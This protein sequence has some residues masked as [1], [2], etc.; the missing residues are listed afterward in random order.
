[1]RW[2]VPPATEILQPDGDWIAGPDLPHPTHGAC[3]AALDSLETRHLLAGGRIKLSDSDKPLSLR[4]WLHSSSTPGQWQAVDDL[5]GVPRYMSACAK[6]T[7]ANGDEVV[8][9]A[10]GT[11]SGD[12]SS[13]VVMFDIATSKWNTGRAIL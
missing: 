4:A 5:P 13:E 3:V 8:V 1:M 10:G 11:V 2:Y 12:G 9:L 7:L 6:H